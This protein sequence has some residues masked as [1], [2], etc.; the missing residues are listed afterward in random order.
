[1]GVYM[2]D[3]LELNKLAVKNFDRVAG[4]TGRRRTPMVDWVTESTYL[5]EKSLTKDQFNT[6]VEE[7]H[8]ICGSLKYKKYRQ[9]YSSGKVLYKHV[10]EEVM[11]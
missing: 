5:S 11:Y 9:V 8:Q 7:H 2:N 6:I 4:Y 10:L 3:T 1:M